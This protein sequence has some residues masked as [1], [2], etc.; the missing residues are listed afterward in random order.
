MILPGVHGPL[1][2]GCTAAGPTTSDDLRM[3]NCQCARKNTNKK[4]SNVYIYIY[5]YIYIC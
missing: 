5:I 4:S 2:G 1:P 3:A